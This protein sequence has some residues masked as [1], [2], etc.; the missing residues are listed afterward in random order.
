MTEECSSC[1]GT[2]WVWNTRH[3]VRPCK[4]CLPLWVRV[5]M[6]VEDKVPYRL[7][8]IACRLVKHHNRSCHG[9]LDHIAGSLTPPPS[10]N[11]HTL[12]SGQVLQGV[13]PPTAC[14]GRGC[15]L[16][17]PTP[18]HMVEWGLLWRGDRGLMERLCPEHGTGH[19]DPDHM[20]WYATT[21]TPNDTWAEGV[22]G[23]CGC[24]LPPLPEAA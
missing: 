13:H 9:R 3:H 18:H 2:G 7:G 24:C 14:E 17:H 16:H 19:P 10:T 1:R 11:T 20:A 6:L 5:A 8:R 22:H 21:H 12:S 15:P 23:C 4:Q